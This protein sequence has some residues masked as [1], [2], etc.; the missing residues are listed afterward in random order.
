MLAQAIANS[1][2]TDADFVPQD[3]EVRAPDP[4]R[5]EALVGESV[6]DFRPRVRNHEREAFRNFADEQNGGTLA[7]LFQPP[8]DL[9]FSGSFREA[10]QKGADE[11]RYLV[12][13]I[14]AV[15][16]FA[17]H[18]LNR[19]TWKDKGLRSVLK[20]HG[21]LWQFYGSEA[22]GQEFR[23]LYPACCVT[24]PQVAIIDP[25]TGELLHNWSR[26]A[27]ADAVSKKLSELMQSHPLES[28]ERPS[29]RSK[30]QNPR[31]DATED[32]MLAAAIAASLSDQP[33][34]EEEDVAVVDVVD[35]SDEADEA[36]TALP[37][38]EEPPEP[39]SDCSTATKLKIRLPDHTWV[40]RR[41]EV[42]STVEL[43]R[44]FVRWKI[45]EACTREFELNQSYPAKTLE[46]T[47][48]TLE[49]AGLKNAQVLANWVEETC[50]E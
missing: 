27:P 37:S 8:V 40:V 29:K 44:Q 50:E 26:E 46:D 28:L 30:V 35:V 36:Q 3:P 14:Q 32:D 6:Y 21:I 34:E 39:P 1:M 38:R 49:A 5:N 33:A 47:S 15:D 41:F 43:V 2:A 16:E 22:Q 18:V 13:N 12:V 20:K 7:N 42:S 31:S 17:S 24:L 48:E 25:R 11:H 23:S 9:L 19:D 4:V 45:P 10:K